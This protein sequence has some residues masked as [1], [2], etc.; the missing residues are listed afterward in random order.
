MTTLKCHDVKP[1]I[2]PCQDRETEEICTKDKTKDGDECYWN[3][4]NG[5]GSCGNTPTPVPSPEHVCLP[6]CDNGEWMLNGKSVT[7]KAV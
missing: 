3:V 1:E 2:K 6:V 7:D 5:E 4:V